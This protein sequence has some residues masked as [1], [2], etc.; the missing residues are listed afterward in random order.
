MKYVNSK[1]FIP[2]LHRNEFRSF[3]VIL[4]KKNNLTAACKLQTCKLCMAFLGYTV[5]MLGILYFK[6]IYVAFI[7]GTETFDTYIHTL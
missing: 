6:F 4:I 2:A 1:H 7:G 3:F 5:E